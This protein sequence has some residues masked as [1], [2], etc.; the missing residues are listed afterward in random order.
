MSFTKEQLDERYKN[1]PSDIKAA[2]DSTDTYEDLQEISKKYGLLID[3]AGLLSEEVT[4]T[5]LGLESSSS[6]VYRLRENLGV[7]LEVAQSMGDDINE[8]IFKDFRDSL[9]KI[10]SENVNS[11]FPAE[12]EEEEKIDREDLLREIERIDTQA[13]VAPVETEK[14]EHKFSASVEPVPSKNIVEQKLNAPVKSSIEV[15]NLSRP[16]EKTRPD[17]G[18]KIDPY[19]EP[20]E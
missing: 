5:L 6:L 13:S 15:V 12:N 8:K 10:H 9:M 11:K 1:L 18:L 16:G 17:P 14:V 20:I 7:S 3:K 19:R 2:L 4:L